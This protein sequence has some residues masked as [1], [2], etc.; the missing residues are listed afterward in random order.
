MQHNKTNK[1]MKA[2]DKTGTLPSTKRPEVLTR[3]PYSITHAKGNPGN[4]HWG[5]L[6]LQPSMFSP[7]HCNHIHVQVQHG[8]GEAK[9]EK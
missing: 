4:C 1:N 7:A 2:S 3:S 5:S 8:E 6:V 9:R